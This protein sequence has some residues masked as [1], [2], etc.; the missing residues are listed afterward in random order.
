MKE[1][2]FTGA[3]VAI[4]TPMN[5]DGTVNMMNSQNLLTGSLKMAQM[6]LLSAEQ[7]EKAQ[8]LRL[9]SILNV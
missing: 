2:I 3:A 1:P 9:M 8:H 5:E 4:I 7:Q 6:P